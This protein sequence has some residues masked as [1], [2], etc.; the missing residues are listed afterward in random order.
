MVGNEGEGEHSGRSAGF[1]LGV[2]AGLDGVG[3]EVDGL[4]A[5]TKAPPQ[6]SPRHTLVHRP[7]PDRG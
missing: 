3:V 6:P 7:S 2:E 1:G 4:E 5:G